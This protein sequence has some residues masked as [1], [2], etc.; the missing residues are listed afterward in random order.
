MISFWQIPFREQIYIHRAVL[1]DGT[2]LGGEK[3]A[4][5]NF[6]GK[7]GGFVS[8]K[9]CL[10]ICA[11]KLVPRECECGLCSSKIVMGTIQDETGF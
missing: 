3:R 9:L 7:G 4:T 5:K 1:R 6:T 8:K 11:L 2:S 10:L